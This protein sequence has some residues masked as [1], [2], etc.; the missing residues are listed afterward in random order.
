MV[1]QLA[2]GG[3]RRLFIWNKKLGATEGRGG[4]GRFPQCET[5]PMRR[6]SAGGLLLFISEQ[7]LHDQGGSSAFSAVARRHPTATDPR[8]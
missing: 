7:F 8:R 2:G 1:R 4:M 5:A 3:L 6:T